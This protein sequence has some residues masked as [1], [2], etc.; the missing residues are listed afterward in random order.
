MN[1]MDTKVQ[2]D[3]KI[4]GSTEWIKIL[5]ITRPDVRTGTLGTVY[6]SA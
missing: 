5:L 6:P 1:S 3:Y 4:E 2:C